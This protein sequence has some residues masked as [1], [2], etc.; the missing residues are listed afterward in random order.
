MDGVLKGLNLPGTSGL[1]QLGLGLGSYAWEQ[2]IYSGQGQDFEDEVDAEVRR[3]ADI[4]DEGPA[5][6]EEE[7]SQEGDERLLKRKTRIV[8][9]LVERPKTVYERFPTFSRDKILDFSELFKGFAVKKSRI[10]K[11]P[12]NGMSPCSL[13]TLIYIAIVVEIVVPKAKRV[14]R[15]Y[16]TELV[17]DTEREV[18]TRRVEQVVSSSTVE[19][20]LR[21]ALLERSA[22]GRTPVHLPL[23][24]RSFDLVLLSDWESQIIYDMDTGEH[25]MDISQ[26]ADGPSTAH[27][28]FNPNKKA[29]EVMTPANEVLE[30]GDWTQSIIWDSKTP[31]RDFTQLEIAEPTPEPEAYVTGT[32]NLVFLLLYPIHH[33]ISDP[34][35]PKK[36]LRADNVPK[37]KFNISNDQQYEVSKEVARQRVRQTFQDLHIQHSYPAQKLQLPFVSL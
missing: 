3:E 25:N 35:R 24:E 6:K 23:S 2:N 34:N 29:E 8:K 14:A 36:R 13:A 1:G 7:A 27:A 12:F 11:K 20:D 19:D 21:K 10:T 32:L 28:E 31:F 22:L 37:D 18:E 15:G 5:V 26:D 17:G 16:L 33:H 4:V 30:S 9:K